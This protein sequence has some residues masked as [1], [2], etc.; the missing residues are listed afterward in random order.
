MAMLRESGGT[1]A[2]L[3]LNGVM[4]FGNADELSREVDELFKR[5]DM[6]LLDLEGVTDVDFS[7]AS[8]LRYELVK[9]ARHRK[10]LLF[11]GV[12]PAAHELLTDPLSGAA[13]PSSV[14]FADRD[15]ALEWMEE[16]ALSQASRA[17]PTRLPLRDH[18]L[19]TG[20][21]PEEFAVMER[22]IEREE[23]PAG[24]ILCREGDEA[25]RMWILT[26]GSVS[27]RVLSVG[28]TRDRRIASL[29]FGTI[30]G[31]IAFVLEAG[32]RTATIIADDDIECYVLNKA[33]FATIVRDH[34]AIGI[35]LIANMLREV[36]QRLRIT[37]DEL[38]VMTR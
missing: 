1:R 29:A 25:D 6:V 16:R 8:I 11:S 22:L 24:T 2:V 38:R 26:R 35:K 36:T 14:I 9:S 7:A 17:A 32:R 12:P 3:E 5:A 19:F 10:A 28:Q 20:L 34:P 23:Y 15:A 30:V 27:V 31:E 18:Q 33:S 4:F 37:S 21:T 13:L